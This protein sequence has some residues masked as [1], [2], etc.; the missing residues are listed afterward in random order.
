MEKIVLKGSRRTITGKKVGALRREGKL[1][2]VL[3]GHHVEPLP[4][5]LDLREASRILAGVSSSRILTLDIDGEEF[6]TLVREK[7]RDTIRARFTH[8][9]FQAV[10]LTEKINAMVNI[11][12][13]GES[14]AVK[15]Y[16]GMVDIQTYEIEVES[17]PQFLPERIDV[18]ISNLVKIGDNLHVKDLTVSDEVKILA[19]P[20]R[21]IVSITSMG[22]EAEAEEVA[23]EAAVSSEPE[24]IERGKKEE[25]E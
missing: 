18:D 24:V 4:I 11:N 7:Q 9:D 8:I 21:I 19:D 1:P 6:A 20:D 22:V 13:V 16:N 15:L 25:E 5:T 17:L 23:A 10:S 14:P 2:A 12:I 3:Y